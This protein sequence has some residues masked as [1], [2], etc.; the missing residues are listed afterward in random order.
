MAVA[1]IRTYVCFGDPHLHY[2]SLVRAAKRGQSVGHWTI[3]PKAERNDRALFY[4]TGPM[5]SF[6]A[7]G[8]VRTK[9]SLA[10]G[11]R[12]DWPGKAMSVIGSIELFP[13][14]VPL[15]GLRQ[16]MPEWG[17]LRFPKKSIAVPEHL[18]PQ[19][20]K[21]LSGLKRRSSSR[22][23]ARQVFPDEV[24]D[25]ESYV[26][27]TTIRIS[28]NAFERN[29][30][31]RQRCID[32]YGYSCVVCGFSFESFYG[33]RASRIIHVHHLKP[34]SEIGSEYVLEPVREL[35]P[36]CPNCHAMIHAQ[37]PPYTIDE[38]KRFIRKRTPN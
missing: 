19:L 23:N 4:M 13:D 28:I 34:L 27:G 17:F 16:C 25:P 20:E 12:F 14:A 10:A 15:G 1:T 6:V 18:I 30:K 31:A 8:T 24:S 2:P 37:N 5:S 7:W 21:C 33:K 35:R 22:L 11:E 26:E 38:V 36:V 3:N 9:A 32:H 29:R